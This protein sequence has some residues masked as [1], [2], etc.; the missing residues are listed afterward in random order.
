MVTV[1][2]LTKVLEGYGISEIEECRK[3]WLRP[4]EI[5]EAVA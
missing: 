2:R 4:T 5:I 1:L 3:S